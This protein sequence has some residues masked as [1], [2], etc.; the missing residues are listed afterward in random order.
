[1]EPKHSVIK[2]LCCMSA[3]NLCPHNTLKPF[4]I[5]L[6]NLNKEQLKGTVTLM[7]TMF[8]MRDLNKPLILIRVSSKLVA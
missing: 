5:S 4:F 7:I 3:A 1:M 6:D 8:Y 2:G